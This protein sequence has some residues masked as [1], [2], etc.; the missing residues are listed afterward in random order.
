M[1]ETIIIATNGVGFYRRPRALIVVTEITTAMI[2]AVR[3]CK[4]SST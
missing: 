4:P 2:A 1:R 3:Y